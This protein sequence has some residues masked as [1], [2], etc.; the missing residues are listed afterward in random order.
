MNQERTSVGVASCGG[1]VGVA[2]VC[3]AWGAPFPLSRKSWDLRKQSRANFRANVKG[4]SVLIFRMNLKTDKCLK[5]S[6]QVPRQR[7]AAA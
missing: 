2:M 7:R 6:C 5:C 4:N 1:G 3:G